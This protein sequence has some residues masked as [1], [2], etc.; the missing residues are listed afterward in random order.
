LRWVEV[1]Q[2]RESC[3]HAGLIGQRRHHAY[4]RV[5]FGNGWGKGFSILQSDIFFSS[6]CLDHF[7]AVGDIP[8]AKSQ[9]QWGARFQAKAR[10][11]YHHLRNEQL[12]PF[13][14]EASGQQLD[15][16]VLE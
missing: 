14:R 16:L 7:I 15:G 12:I 4:H 3:G 10:V 13:L 9:V 11:R 8:L 6:P 1:R 5:D 2:G